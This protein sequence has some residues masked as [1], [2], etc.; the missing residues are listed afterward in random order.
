MS[1]IT[2]RC[3]VAG[4]SLNMIERP[5]QRTR[6]PRLDDTRR[7]LDCSVMR[8]ESDVDVL[9]AESCGVDPRIEESEFGKLGWVMDPDGNRVE[10]WEPPL[11]PVEG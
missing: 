10:L 4:T 9:R 8:G 1:R 6:P 11:E 2:L 5:D 3:I 7:P